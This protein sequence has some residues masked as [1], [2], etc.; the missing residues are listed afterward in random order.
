MKL[1]LVTRRLLMLFPTILRANGLICRGW[2]SRRLN[3][4]MDAVDFAQIVS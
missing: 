1:Q 4:A 2:Y 3:N